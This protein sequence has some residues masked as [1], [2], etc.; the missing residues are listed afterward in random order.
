MLRDIVTADAGPS[1]HPF[2]LRLAGEHRRPGTEA[3]ATAQAEPVSGGSL[4]HQAPLIPKDTVTAGEPLRIELTRSQVTGIS[5]QAAASG[6]TLLPQGHDA[7]REALASAYG[8]IASMETA[9]VSSSLLVGLLIFAAFPDDGAAIANA[10]LACALKISASTCHRYLRTLVAVG[11]VER[12]PASRK[13]RL[14]L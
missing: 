1:R 11:L 5:E 13:Y 4:R 7:R 8:E 3:L 6:Y 12:A 9:R 2:R 10:E 14:A